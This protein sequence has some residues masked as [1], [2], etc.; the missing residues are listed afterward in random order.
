MSNAIKTVRYKRKSC[1][2]IHEI[3]S[4][5]KLILNMQLFLSGCHT[6]A[7]WRVWRWAFG[8]VVK[9]PTSHTARPGFDP[10]F[11]RF[12]LPVNADPG[13]QSWIELPAP[14]FGPGPHSHCRHLGNGSA[15]GNFLYYSHINKILWKMELN[16]KSI[17]VQKKKKSE[18][19]ACL[20]SS[21]SSWKMHTVKKT[22]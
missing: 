1:N 17:L 14:D 21:K 22:T 16:D 6:G 15:D 19:H 20:K 11:C 4:P 9:R 2:N 7:L 10:Q 5:W 8:L 18:T 3:F 13:R 12:W